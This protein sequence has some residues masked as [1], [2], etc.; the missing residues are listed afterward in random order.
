[1]PISAKS[2]KST[3]KS[4]KVIESLTRIT[5]D[6]SLGEIVE[7]FPQTTEVMLDFGL[8]CFGCH[9]AKF[10]TLEQGAKAHGLEDEQ[11]EELLKELNKVVKA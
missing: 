8:H 4:K 1:M 2:K 3:I 10:E 6:M 11:I 9:I 5:K 7:R